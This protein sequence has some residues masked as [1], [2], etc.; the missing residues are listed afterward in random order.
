MS[1]LTRSLSCTSGY[2]LDHCLR[3]DCVPQFLTRESVRQY[4]INQFAFGAS[5]G[6]QEYGYIGDVFAVYRARR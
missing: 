3:D 6:S 4:G 1:L 2:L 5:N